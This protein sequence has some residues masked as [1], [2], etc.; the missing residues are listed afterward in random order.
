MSDRQWAGMMLGDE[1]YA[2]SA[3]STTSSARCRST[4]ATSTSSRR[5]RAAAPR[6]SSAE[7]P[8]PP[9]DYVPG[10]MYFTTTR[11]TRSSPARP[12]ST[13]SSTR[14]T[15]RPNEHPFK[16]NVDAGE[17]RRA[18]RARRPRRRSR[19]SPSPATVNMAGGQPISMAEP[20]RGVGVLPRARG[21]R[22]SSTRRAPSRTPGS[23][24]SARPGYADAPSR[25]SCARRARTP[26][27]A[28]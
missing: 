9:G 23:S 10:N 13:S 8:D 12:S 17:A 3:T 14:P 24:S 2:G 22:S 7:V 25:R 1:A 26:T 20:P 21:S 15:T 11:R 28:P 18:R 5:T 6:T 19:T 4:T 16:G 27:A